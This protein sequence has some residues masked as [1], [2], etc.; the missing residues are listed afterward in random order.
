MAFPLHMHSSL[1]AEK[2]EQTIVT[3][4][5]DV[6]MIIHPIWGGKYIRR[7]HL[8]FGAVIWVSGTEQLGLLLSH[9]PSTP[10]IS[11]PLMEQEYIQDELS[12]LFIH[13]H[14]PRL[15]RNT[16]VSMTLVV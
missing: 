2:V 3:S 15:L 4:S 7:A 16:L 5:N 8:G 6:T 12:S 14:A 13:V 10:A 1:P 11:V 9:R